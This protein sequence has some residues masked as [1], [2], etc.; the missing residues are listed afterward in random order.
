M[1]MS[2][3][4]KLAGVTAGYFV[5]GI[6]GAVVGA[7]AGHYVLDKNDE[8][9]AFAIALIALSAKMSMA[10]GK[11]S[12]KEFIAFKEILN[13]LPE[14][15]LKNVTKIYN[16]ARE[17][18]AGY[19]VYA[20]QISSIFQNN[21]HVLENVIDALFHVAKADGPIN[22]NEVIFLEKIAGIFGFSSAE[23]SRIRASHMAA[24]IDDPWLILGLDSGSSLNIAKSQ[25]K[26]LAAE[27]HPDRLI[28]KGVPKE[29]LGM[30]NE[31]LA[32]INSAYRKIEKAHKMKAGT[33]EI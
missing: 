9:V 4:G 28:S 3:W 23:F 13:E 7:V 24:D 29:L 17:D 16:L 11:I 33:G 6:F 1:L 2:V 15:E 26:K 18:I 10:D 5:G 25:W 20:K 21:L 27:N 14:N 30:A 19:D 31:K 32:V 12:D 22:K 8:D